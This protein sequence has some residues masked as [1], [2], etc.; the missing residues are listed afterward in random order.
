[1][2]LTLEELAWIVASGAATAVGGLGLLVLRRPS[3]RALDVLMA[4]TAGIMLAAT[5]F[6]LLVPALDLGGVGEVV[7]GLLAGA[8]CLAALDRLVPHLH[9]RLVE[10]G[11]TG[12]VRRDADP[13]AQSRGLLLLIAMAIHN[14]PEGMA[15]GLAFA[16]GG[17]EL[18]IPIA[19][20]IGIQNIPEGFA[21]AAPLLDGGASR[22]QAFG[23][24]AATGAFE[25][26]AAIGAIAVAAVVAVLL[27]AGLAFAAGAMLYVVIDELVPEAHAGSDRAATLALIVG[28]ALMM[29][30]D[31]TLG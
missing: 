20:A 2:D 18:G 27:P 6:S 11:R 1:M 9:A 19:L 17:T 12:L 7:A 23:F 14:V 10:R 4:F 25:P 29:T 13:A 31:T 22:R 26:P 8:A 28:F 3:E 5:M 16:A 15:V 30:L 21:A 24:A